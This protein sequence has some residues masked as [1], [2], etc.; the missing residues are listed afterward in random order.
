MTSS[1]SEAGL[2]LSITRL[3]LADFGEPSVSGAAAGCCISGSAGSSERA[4]MGLSRASASSSG[5]VF[6]S[7]WRRRKLSL[8]LNVPI[9][10]SKRALSAA[11]RSITGNW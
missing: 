5:G 11:G 9:M 10:L 3:P 1:S 4:G 2:L 7:G 8:L 6:P